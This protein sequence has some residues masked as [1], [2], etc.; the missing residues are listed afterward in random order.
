MMLRWRKPPL[1]S[2]PRKLR[3][4]PTIQFLCALSACP[5]ARFALF[6]FCD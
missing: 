6:Q 3:K 1:A 2:I 5:M 4:L